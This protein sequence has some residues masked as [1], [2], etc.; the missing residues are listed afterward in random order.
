M[1]FIFIHSLKYI[2]NFVQKCARKFMYVLQGAENQKVEE[3]LP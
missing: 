1:I 3:P 2:N